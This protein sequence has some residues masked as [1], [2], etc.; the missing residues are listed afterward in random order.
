[1]DKMRAERLKKL[2]GQEGYQKN[3]KEYKDSLEKKDAD[4]TLKIDA[5]L[6]AMEQDVV[7]PLKSEELEKMKGQKKK[8]KKSLL[9]LF[10]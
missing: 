7:G 10:D 9:D 5:L 8:K 3:L 6:R 2:Q 4:K 1:M